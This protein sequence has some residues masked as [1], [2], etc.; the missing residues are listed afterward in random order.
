MRRGP[1]SSLNLVPNGPLTRKPKFTLPRNP[2]SVESVYLP[3]IRPPRRS[4]GSQVVCQR[5]PTLRSVEDLVSGLG[6]EGRAS[7]SS[8]GSQY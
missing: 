4:V 5:L 3:D 7:W 1:P 6:V 8:D 2:Q